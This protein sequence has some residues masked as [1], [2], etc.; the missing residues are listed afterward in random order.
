M[1]DARDPDKLTTFHEYR[2]EEQA[3][4][5]RQRQKEHV[6]RSIDEGHEKIAK[7]EYDEL[8]ELI[9]TV[10]LETLSISRWNL[11][12]YDRKLDGTEYGWEYGSV[13]EFFSD[14]RLYLYPAEVD[15]GAEYLDRAASPGVD[16][17]QYR[18]KTLEAVF[19]S[20]ESAAIIEGFLPEFL[21]DTQETYG[22]EHQVGERYLN[23]DSSAGG[24]LHIRD[25][26][27]ELKAYLCAG[28]KGSGKSTA[29]DTLA[30]DSYSNGHKIVDI[31]DFF[32]AENGVYDIPQQPSTNGDLID[33]REEMGLQSRFEGGFDKPEIEILAPLSK[34]LEDMRVP[35]EEGED[36]PVLKPFTIPASELTFRQLV[37]L[38]HNTTPT[39]ENHLRS[40]HQKLKNSGKD[41]TLRDV[42]ETVRE[43][44]GAGD[45]VADRIETALETAQGKSF[46]RDTDCDHSLNWSKIMQEQEVITSFTVH[47]IREHSDRLVVMS[48]LIDSL[49]D[50]RDKIVRQHL[51]REFPPLT[52]VMREMHKVAPRSKSEQDAENTIEGYMIDTLSELFALMRH[53]NMEILADTQK[54]KRQLSADVSGLFDRILCFRGHV[55]DVKQ[56][57]KTRLDNTTPAEKVAQFE[58]PGK[59]ALVGEDGYT[60]PIQFAPP[61]CH[62]LEAKQDGSGLAMRARV[63]E[64][65][66]ELI[67][68]P[69]DAE[70]PSRLTFEDLP[71][72]PVAKFCE[73][74]VERTNNFDDFVI[75][76]HLT[77]TYNEWARANDMPVMDGDGGHTRIHRRVKNHFDLDSETDGQKTI[78]VDGE[79]KRK[80]CHWT[81]VLHGEDVET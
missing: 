53:A 46:I 18:R 50:A 24:T 23:P 35:C 31:V 10:L 58:E 36:D 17:E 69:W 20:L 39:Q 15:H 38:L 27:D 45:S 79:K 81:L 80:G 6:R 32:K 28:S 68:A 16:P 43:E 66:E 4:N 70:V 77:D 72:D 41:W 59:A 75:K 76:Q 13:K 67:P 78:E 63:D 1:S 49:Y 2:V 5:L 61:R 74:Y 37:M 19:E 57:F 73:K 33:A 12:E 8:V 55:P 44:T 9:D 22:Y 60:M 21:E 11:D 51:L 40:A 48:Y 34:G 64:T 25:D 56:V 62:H 65:D 29:V 42:A 14:K 54:F 7:G 3:S 52:I 26:S 47:T 30:L 71:D